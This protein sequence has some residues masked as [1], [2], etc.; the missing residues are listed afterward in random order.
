MTECSICGRGSALTGGPIRYCQGHAC[1][2]ACWDNIPCLV[3]SWVETQPHAGEGPSARGAF[4]KSVL[5]TVAHQS[6]S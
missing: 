3:L 4:A 1:C 2:P 6:R 5:E